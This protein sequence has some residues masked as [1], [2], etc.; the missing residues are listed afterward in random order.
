MMHWNTVNGL[1]RE[2][3]LMLM[4]AEEFSQFRLVGGTSLSLQLGHRMSVDIDLFTDAEYRSVDFDAID[5]FL[6]AN[7]DYVTGIGGLPGM[8]KSYFIGTDK[9][10]AVKLDLYYTDA[11]IRPMLV[12]DGVRLASLEDII[13]MKIDVVSRESRKKDFW[14]LH[15]VLPDYTI[16]DMLAL[17]AERMPYAHERQAI[18]MRLIDFEEADDDF[19]PECLHGKYWEF[20]KEDI[21]QAVSAV[22]QQRAADDGNTL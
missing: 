20:I 19:N 18:L 1:L 2:S 11:F 14:D 9:D 4:A 15:Q 21:R 13:A 7:F 3:L 16:G 8:G 5:A 12:E 10:N 22:P 17:H 6:Q